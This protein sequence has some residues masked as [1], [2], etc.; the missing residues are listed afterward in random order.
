M[1]QTVRL[2][3]NSFIGK[4]YEEIV[5]EQIKH[6]K[7]KCVNE[8]KVCFSI[9]EGGTDMVKKVATVAQSHLEALQLKT[10]IKLWE[11]C[12][13]D[14]IFLDVYQ[15]DKHTDDRNYRFSCRGEAP[16]NI[17]QGFTFLI[18]HYQFIRSQDHDHFTRGKKQKRNDSINHDYN[19]K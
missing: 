9:T 15:D 6:A 4:D 19:K 14:F 7:E 2:D 13:K 10:T 12:K 16:Y 3:A 17:I 5:W 11:N 8:F 18:D 1:I